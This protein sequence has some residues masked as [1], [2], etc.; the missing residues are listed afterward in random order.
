MNQDPLFYIDGKV[1][2][3]TGAAGVI[4]SH[5]AQALA[6]RGAAVALL[7]V[8]RV[9]P[10]NHHSPLQAEATAQAI[11]DAGGRALAL[12]CNVFHVDG[13]KAALREVV[14]QLGNVDVLING[15]GGNQKAA[16]V[17]PTQKFT[18]LPL[19][20]MRSV[21]D[22]NLMGTFIPCQVFCEHFA[23]IG[24]GVIINTSSMCA[25]A[26]LTNIPGYSAAKAAVTN[27][28]RWLAAQVRVDF[29]GTVIRVNEI[30]PGFLITEQNRNLLL[31]P[32]ESPK[33]RAVSVLRRTPMG[34]FGEP[35]ELVGALVFLM[36][37][38]STF[39]TGTTVVVDGGF[40]ACSG[41]GPLDE[42]DGQFV[43]EVT[44]P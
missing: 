37:Q 15:A 12:F 7:D 1:I 13:V 14:L 43:R 33:P 31:N 32:D 34:R 6:S 3:I 39:V 28:T 16:T 9:D 19:D 44:L 5:V 21:V 24:Q 17:Q 18:E 35:E 10:Q 42:K 30:A 8:K 27:L 22:L 29:P 38:A 20:A 11:R 26:P 23:Q 40:A 2:V 41:V 36:S 4:Y 25:F